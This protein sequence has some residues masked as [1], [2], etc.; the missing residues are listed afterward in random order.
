M[1]MLRLM[2]TYG[3]GLDTLPFKRTARS[4]NAQA[5]LS[6]RWSTCHFVSC[7]M[8]RP[9]FLPEKIIHAIKIVFI[10]MRASFHKE[11]IFYF[12][13]NLFG[14]ALSSWEENKKSH[15]YFLTV[16]LEGKTWKC[17]HMS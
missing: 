5:V 15:R 6:L 12:M 16:N 1:R 3:A 14:R 17:I 11:Q 10:S 7:A 9:R 2:G 4:L 13:N 8:S